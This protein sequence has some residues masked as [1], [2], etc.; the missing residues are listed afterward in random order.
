MPDFSSSVQSEAGG[1]AP[2]RWGRFPTS[3]LALG[4]LALCTTSCSS[5]DDQRTLEPIQLGMTSDMG[6]I[7]E[8]NEMSIYEVKLPIDFPI[9]AP[10]PDQQAAL[11]AQ[12]APPFAHAPW[13]LNSDLQIQITWTLSNLDPDTHNVEL[14]VD[15]HNEFG[16]Y[17]AGMAVTDAQREQQAPN[18]S[19]IDILM[20]VPG[21]DSGRD[22][23]RHGT[24]TVQDMSELA[25]DFATVQ[26]II[27][28]APPPDLTADAKDS[29]AIGLVN[30]AFNVQNRSYDD[31]LIQGYIPPVI[32]GLTGI[33][34]GLRTYE[35]ANV[36]IE[37]VVEV[38]D[39]GTGKVVQR[40]DDGKIPLLP[41]NTTYVTLGG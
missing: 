24:F 17:W 8:D 19:G 27:A 36:A 30:H 15:P 35:P 13:L 41:P 26:N 34:L 20:E 16:V 28:T 40:E 9:A 4:L 21:T 14:L 39:K 38:V 29:P 5:K 37:I 1:I 3:C 31:P 6:A 2:A 12:A 7:Y 33:D 10:T 22:S 25:I 23:R 11:N 18:L 32:P